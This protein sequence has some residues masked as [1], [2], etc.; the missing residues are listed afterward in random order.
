MVEYYYYKYI[1]FGTK[2]AA[3]S[4]LMIRLNRRPDSALLSG[5]KS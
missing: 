2:K 3:D 4:N 1:F 5:V